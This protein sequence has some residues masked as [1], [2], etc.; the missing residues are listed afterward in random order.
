MCEFAASLTELE[1]QAAQYVC[2]PSIVVPGAYKAASSTLFANI[3]KHP[4]VLRVRRRSRRNLGHCKAAGLTAC[5]S[6]HVGVQPLVGSNFKETGLYLGLPGRDRFRDRVR[7]FP[8]I[9]QHESFATIDATVFYLN[10]HDSPYQIQ[11]DRYAQTNTTHAAL[12]R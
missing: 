12:T 1:R 2:A 6:C 4:Q 3:A 11:A 5:L 10:S 7:G 9:D 8:F